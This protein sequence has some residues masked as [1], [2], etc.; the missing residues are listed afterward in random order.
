MYVYENWVSTKL[1]KILELLESNG[2]NAKEI[3]WFS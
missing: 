1:T 3:R 2:A